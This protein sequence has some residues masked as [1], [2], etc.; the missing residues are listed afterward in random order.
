MSASDAAGYTLRF[1]QATRQFGTEYLIAWS[2]DEGVTWDTTAINTDIPTNETNDPSL[3]I[4]EIPMPSAAGADQLIVKFIGVGNYYWWI[5]DDVQIVE[6]KAN[7]LTLPENNY[8]LAT[9]AQTPLALASPMTFFANVQNSGADDQTNVT[10]QIDITGPDGDNVFTDQ[11]LY[12]S[13]A[14]NSFV[15]DGQD[16]VFPNTFT[17]ST[18]GTYTGTYTVFADEEDEDPID[19]T[20]TFTFAV[21]NDENGVGVLAKE[22]NGP[23]G[24]TRPA[25]GNW[26]AT[27]PFFL[28]LGKCLLH[29]RI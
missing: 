29:S 2:P 17:P 15:P 10:V 18:P 19:N 23:T 27:D 20:R 12:E 8:L 24:N 5:I 7:N 28:C 11:V 26:G 22:L 16:Q 21:N 9:N 25:D 3:T 6:Q 13:L 14:A 4:Q 1:F